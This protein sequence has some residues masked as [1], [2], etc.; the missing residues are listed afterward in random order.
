MEFVAVNRFDASPK[1]HPMRPSRRQE[2]VGGLEGVLNRM[3]N[4]DYS[5]FRVSNLQQT[6]DESRSIDRETTR[7][8]PR[9]LVIG[10]VYLRGSPLISTLQETLVEFTALSDLY[11]GA[12]H[13]LMPV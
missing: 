3:L 4:G 7:R 1:R 6:Q 2:R 11:L 5:S 12:L 10:S 8:S 9:S 13:P